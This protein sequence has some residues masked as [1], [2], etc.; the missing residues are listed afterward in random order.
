MTIS[1]YLDNNAWD[2]LFERRDR[3]D[4]CAEL[5][6]EQFSLC[7][8]REGEFEIEPITGEKTAFIEDTIARCGVRTDTL[9][10]FR[11][12]R[13]PPEE[14]RVGGFGSGGRWATPDELELAARCNTAKPKRRS[15]LYP[16]EAAYALAGRSFHAVVLTRDK[17]N[18]LKD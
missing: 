18:P 17:R 6:P 12:D 9:F 5:P 8:T 3:I 15:G 14:Q 2:Y 4:L 16:K 13:H 11:D 10:G 1:V 7:I